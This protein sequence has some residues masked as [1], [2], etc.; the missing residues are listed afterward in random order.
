VS[1]RYEFIDAEKATTTPDGVRKYPIV[2]MCEWLEVSTSGY[3]EW[4]DRPRSA[5]A[6]R[7]AHL[8]L[9]IKKVFDDSDA[10]YGYRRVHAQLRV[11]ASTARQS[12]SG[13]SCVSWA[14]WRVSRG[15]GGTA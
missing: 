7:R 5:T 8:Q 6:T 14:W 3:Y 12:W 11:G 4:R 1:A 2:K 13:R 9:L 10:T 15:R